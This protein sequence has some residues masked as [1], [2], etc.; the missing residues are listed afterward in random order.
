MDYNSLNQILKKFSKHFEIKV[1]GKTYFKRKIFAV[2]RNLNKNFATA[3]FVASIHARENIATDLLCKMIEES[4][5]SGIE[6]FN[7]SFILMANP[8]GVELAT[9]GLSSFSKKHQKKL[10]KINK[11]SNDFKL[12]KAN[13]RGV[14]LNNNFDARFNTNVH[15]NVATSSGYPGRRPESEMETKAIVKYLKKKNPFIVIC[16][17]T[18]GEEIYYNFFQGGAYLERDRIIAEKFAESTGYVIKNP[19]KSSSGGLKDY[20]V[21]KLKIPSLT[22]E[23]GNDELTHPIEKEYLEEIFERNKSVAKDLVFAYNVFDRFRGK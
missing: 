12:W 7:L 23:L 11:N 4:V 2:E 17:H 16:Y 15:A 6:N 21:E 1:I 8:D 18:K 19:E 10:L 22:I 20:V 9:N 14:D 3:I 5:F 13:A